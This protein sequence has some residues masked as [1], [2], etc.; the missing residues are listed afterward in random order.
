[1][2]KLILIFLFG[3][4]LNSSAQNPQFREWM[5]IAEEDISLQPEYGNVE[6]T[7]DEKE[8]DA[9]F[10]AKVMEEMKNTVEASEKMIE[11][12]F[13][14]LYERGDLVAAMRK[15]NEA[16]LLNPEN[17]DIYL[18][19]GTVYTTLG[20]FLEAREQ[21][22]KGLKLAPR[23][24][25]LVTAYGTTFLGEYYQKFDEDRSAAEA[26]LDHALEYFLESEKIDRSNSDTM[27]KLSIVYLYKDNCKLA[28]KYFREAKKLEHPN[29]PPR[30]EQQL[31]ASC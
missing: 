31:K 9:A 3:I 18:G 21:Y 2:K 1:M 17:P 5:E 20:A 10:I 11:L 8:F 16:Y 25:M 26:S 7:A 27:F 24:P 28:I 13:Q 30:Y 12:G 6:K 14:Y 29:I 4:I 15:F 23:D 22:D 19:Y